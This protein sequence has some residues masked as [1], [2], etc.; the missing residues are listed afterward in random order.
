M[1][2]ELLRGILTKSYQVNTPEA[3]FHFFASEYRFIVL[4]AAKYSFKILSRAKY[5]YIFV[6]P[7][8]LMYTNNVIVIPWVVRLYVEIIHEL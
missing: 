8:I 3:G 1:V 4:I 5:I 2:Y 6:K 7:D